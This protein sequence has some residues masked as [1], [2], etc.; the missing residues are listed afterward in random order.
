MAHSVSFLLLLSLFLL[1]H[2]HPSYQ[3]DA[4][5][6]ISCRKTLLSTLSPEC[7]RYLERT[8][9]TSSPFPTLPTATS[10]PTSSFLPFSALLPTHAY[11]S[12]SSSPALPTT[13]SRS[14]SRSNP[15]STPITA[16]A[17]STIRSFLPSNDT[18][19]RIQTIQKQ[20][21]TLAHTTRAL[22]SSFASL[23]SLYLA[24][25]AFLKVRKGFSLRRSFSLGLLGQTDSEGIGAG[26]IPLRIAGPS[27]MVSTI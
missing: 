26:S 10:T 5:L 7:K 8:R 23:A 11:P 21:H 15:H 20:T 4:F 13:S 17:S 16:S 2:S 9:T 19:A 22:T 3:R 14:T 27:P 18:I 24:V 1:S 25:V 6:R 12:R